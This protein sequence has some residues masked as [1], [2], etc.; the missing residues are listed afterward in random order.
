MASLNRTVYEVGFD[1]SAA[2]SVVQV[3][4]GHLADRWRPRLLVMAGPGVTPGEAEG[5]QLLDVAPTVLELLGID[6]P[7]GTRG[8]SLVENARSSAGRSSRR[9]V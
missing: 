9:E 3:G 2:A 1:R 4:F 6:V 5:M 8:A 7:T